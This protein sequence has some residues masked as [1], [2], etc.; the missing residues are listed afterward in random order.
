MWTVEEILEAS[1]GAL[2]GG[3]SSEKVAGFSIDSRTVRPEELFFALRGP[4]FDGHDFVAQVLEKGAAGAIVARSEFHRREAE[5]RPGLNRRF[6]ITVEEPLSALQAMAA[7]RRRRFSV[8]VVG[9]T[10]SNGKTTTKEMTAAILSRRGPVLKNEGNLNNHIGLPLT[11]LRLEEGDRAA[12]LEMGIS[13]KGE[14]RLLCGIARPTVGLITN[15]GP[16]HLEFLG[17]LEGVAKEKGDLFEAVRENG[18]AVINRDDPY[19]LP[20]EGRLT[21]AWSYALDRPA[22]VTADDIRQ[23]PDGA[24]FTLHLNRGGEK[25]PARLATVGRHQLYNALA[26]A[27]AACALGCRF[28]EIREGLEMFRPATLRMQILRAGGARVLLDA[29]NANPASMK[30]A[31]QALAEIMPPRDEIGR[32]PR[33]VAALGDMLELGRFAESAHFEV[34][35]AAAKNGIDLLIAV[36]RWASH[37]AEGARK[38]GMSPESVLVYETLEAAQKGLPALIREGDCLLIKG[39]RGMKMESL[40]PALGGEGTK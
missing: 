38:G 15:I 35:E 3:R 39:S 24:R 13:Q 25:G 4:R 40:A 36:G 18:T 5:W 32:P 1:Q 21:R 20:W 16:A 17:D 27:A 33:K 8:P 14:M 23:A 12:V 37:M 22:D 30:A 34:G 26:S 10:G 19:L 11:L 28:D 6:L 29:Y 2:Q 9:V 31:L 7:W